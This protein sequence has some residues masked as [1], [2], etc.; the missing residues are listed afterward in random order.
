MVIVLA[1]LVVLFLA[2]LLI[3]ALTG[4]VRG[5]SCCAVAD[6]RRDKRMSE[7]FTPPIT[8]A[9]TIPAAPEIG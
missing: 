7:A 1:G 2:V 5:N 3:G 6:P 8:P 4:R 9:D